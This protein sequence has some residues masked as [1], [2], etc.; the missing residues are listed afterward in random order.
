MV[1]ELIHLQIMRLMLERV[2]DLLKVTQ[3]LTGNMIQSR[4]QT[5]AAPSTPV[6]VY[7]QTQVKMTIW[8][9]LGVMKVKK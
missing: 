6:S 5:P 8:G 3:R 4:L 1:C 9:E 7:L 2:R